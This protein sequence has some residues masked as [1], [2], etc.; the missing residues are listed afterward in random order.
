M[1]QFHPGQPVFTFWRTF[2]FL[3][4]RR[5]FYLWVFIVVVVGA[6]DDPPHTPRAAAAEPLQRFRLQWQPRQFA[7]AL[8]HAAR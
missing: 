8:A 4:A 5:Q 6:S 1:E 2:P 7:V 3:S